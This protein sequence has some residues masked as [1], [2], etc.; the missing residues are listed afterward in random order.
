MSAAAAS[1]ERESDEFY[2]SRI[3]ISSRCWKSVRPQSSRSILD[4]RVT[5][6]NLAAEELFGYTAEE[7]IGRNLE[8]LVARPR[9]HASRV[10][11]ILRSAR[12]GAAV[13]RCHPSVRKDGTLV[14]VDLFA[15]PVAVEDELTGH[16]VIYYDI[17][18]LKGGEALPGPHRAPSLGHLHRRARRRPLDLHQSSNR[19]TRRLFSGRVAW[20]S[21]S[22]PQAPP[23]RRSRAGPR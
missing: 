19:G 9:R 18:A 23:P 16:L 5:S 4:R 2:G 11:R 20:R 12:T 3:A 1:L 17:S 7:A 21:R 10:L 14:D 22:L 6:W 13:P 8:D 15:V